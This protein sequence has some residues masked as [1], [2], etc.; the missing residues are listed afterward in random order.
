MEGVL[1]KTAKP[2]DKAN[3]NPVKSGQLNPQEKTTGN[4]NLKIQEIRAVRL[5]RIRERSKIM[6]SYL[7]KCIFSG[8]QK[9]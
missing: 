8:S 1:N 7:H 3:L 9:F 2:N 5:R 4:K 6:I